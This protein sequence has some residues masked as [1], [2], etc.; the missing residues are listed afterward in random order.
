MF[1]LLQFTGAVQDQMMRR[2][3]NANVRNIQEIALLRKRKRMDAKRNAQPHLD[4]TWLLQYAPQVEATLLLLLGVFAL[5]IVGVHHHHPHYF[6]LFF[7]LKFS[8]HYTIVI[9]VFA[10]WF[11]PLFNMDLLKVDGLRTCYRM[12]RVI[13]MFQNLYSRKETKLLCV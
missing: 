2:A 5:L 1:D 3:Q 11:V 13:R 7:F 10:V 12:L 8:Y 6:D 4:A 9:K